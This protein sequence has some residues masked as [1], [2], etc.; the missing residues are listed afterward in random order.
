MLAVLAVDE[1]AVDDNG[2]AECFPGRR[3]AATLFYHSNWDF[4]GNAWKFR[5]NFN[6]LN[7]KSLLTVFL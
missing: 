5:S 3:I 2:D 6:N 7:K 4:P 1:V